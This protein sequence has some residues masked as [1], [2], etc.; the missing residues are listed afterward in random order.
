VCSIVGY[1]GSKHSRS[2][3][4]EGLK[5]LEYRGYDSA[6]FACIDD[7][8]H[9]LRSVKSVGGI[10]QLQQKVSMMPVDGYV[11]IGH[12]RWST[13]GIVSDNNAHPHFDCHRTIAVVHNGIIENYHALRADLEHEGHSFVSQTDTETIAHLLEKKYVPIRISILPLLS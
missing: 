1:V 7:Q 2:F 5:R 4:L 13:H 8:I 11:G 6:G 10:A 3:V 9:H 12:T